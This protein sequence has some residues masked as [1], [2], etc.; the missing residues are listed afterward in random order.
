MPLGE[1]RA[2]LSE[3]IGSIEATHERVTITRHGKPV[4]IVLSTE[5]FASLEETLEILASPAARR[6][7]D[8][9]EEALAADDTVDLADL[10]SEVGR[11]E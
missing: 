8:E 11:K 6:A 1:A 4:A 10:L 2:H 9:G 7:I 3:V 5:D